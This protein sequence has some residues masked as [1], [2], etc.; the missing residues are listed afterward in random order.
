M[1][2]KLV[3]DATQ[4][5]GLGDTAAEQNPL[6]ALK[7]ETQFVLDQAEADDKALQVKLAR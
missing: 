5:F 4:R 6:K 2:V 3:A 1:A 7:L